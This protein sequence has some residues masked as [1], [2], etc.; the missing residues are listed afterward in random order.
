MSVTPEVNES[1]DVFTCGCTVTDGSE[2]KTR[3]S[4]ERHVPRIPIGQ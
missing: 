3:R 1:A 2:R 4:V